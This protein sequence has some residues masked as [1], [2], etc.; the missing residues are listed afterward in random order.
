MDRAGGAPKERRPGISQNLIDQTGF[1]QATTE[2]SASRD[3]LRGSERFDRL[4]CASGMKHRSIRRSRSV[5]LSQDGGIP[6]TAVDAGLRAPT[7]ARRAL[8]T[9]SGVAA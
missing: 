6:E 1:R 5:P 7:P 8:G 3:M 4:E 9:D 2:S